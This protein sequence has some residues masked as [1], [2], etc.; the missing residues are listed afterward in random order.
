MPN[1][2]L[3]ETSRTR[4]K[5]ISNDAPRTFGA[6]KYR[7]P[8]SLFSLSKKKKERKN[9]RAR[10]GIK[11][12][13]SVIIL[14]AIMKGFRWRPGDQV[15]LTFH[16]SALCF[17]ASAFKRSRKLCDILLRTGITAS[18]YRFVISLLIIIRQLSTCDA[19]IC[20][21]VAFRFTY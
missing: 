11:E 17:I 16:T 20:T 8:S 1:E 14:R 10:D 2:G 3:I 13:G 19:D 15:T 7:E 5:K 9:R 18:F 12:R 6:L 21:F 4:R